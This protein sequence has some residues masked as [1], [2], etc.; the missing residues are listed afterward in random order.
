MGPRVLQHLHVLAQGGLSGDAGKW[1]QKDNEIIEIL[2]NGERRVRFTP[3]S[4]KDTPGAVKILCDNYDAVC[5]EERL[6]PPLAVASFVF[7]LTCIHPFRDG[8]GRVTRLAAKLLLIQQ[9]YQ[10]GRYVSLERL[11]EESKDEYYRILERCSVDW[12]SGKNEI[13]PWWDYF[14]GI[15][16]RAY[17]EFGRKLEGSGRGPA[18]TELVRQAILSQVGPFSLAELSAQAPAASPALLKKVLNEMKKDR[19]VRLV[20][21]GRGARWEVSTRR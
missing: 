18:K 2:P 19:R 11:V 12:H 20:G 6:P 21:R 15:L 10:V 9:G 4:A 7:D 5:N 16:R 8:N 1:K 13:V 3:T 14:L 17:L